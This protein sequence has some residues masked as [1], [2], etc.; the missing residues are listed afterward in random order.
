MLY[1]FIYLVAFTLFVCS[2]VY[3]VRA[4]NAPYGKNV[5]KLARTTFIMAM[6]AI[7][8][9]VILNVESCVKPIY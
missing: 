1:S 4:I 5:D 7:F 8:L 2:L 3:C 6:S 9:L